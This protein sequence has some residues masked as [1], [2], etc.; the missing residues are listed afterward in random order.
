VV[1]GVVA[2]GESNESDSVDPQEDCL[3]AAAM[4]HR[5][6]NHVVEVENCLFESVSEEDV[7]CAIEVR[8]GLK[9]TGR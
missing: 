9:V 7:L 3:L 1:D 8:E 4:D 6:Q 2:A 5:R